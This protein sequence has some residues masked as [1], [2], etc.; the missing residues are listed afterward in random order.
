MAKNIPDELLED[1]AR[2][3]RVLGDTT[4][5]SLVREIMMAGELSIGALAESAG[6]SQANVSKH[7]RILSD[8]GILSR[9]R[10]GTTVYVSIGDSSI[11]GLC[12]IVCDRLQQ[13][14]EQ[15]GKAFTN[16]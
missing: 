12:D 1:V 16:R 6:A 10:D 13:Q 11:S 9:R 8:A 14:S 4:R 7:L 3:F 5:L 2:R 15:A